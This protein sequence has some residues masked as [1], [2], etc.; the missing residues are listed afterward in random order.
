[1]TTFACR[2]SLILSCRSSLVLFFSPQAPSRL[3]RLPTINGINDAHE[4]AA[5]QGK[6]TAAGFSRA[7]Q[8]MSSEDCSIVARALPML[9][10]TAMVVMMTSCSSLLQRRSGA[11]SLPCSRLATWSSR[12][13]TAPCV[14]LA[15][16]RC[17]CR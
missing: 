15:V 12:A 8:G 17:R 7:L 2:S 1:M 10:L 9:V 6:M 16:H 11:S 3:A 4:F 5:L 13:T 14:A